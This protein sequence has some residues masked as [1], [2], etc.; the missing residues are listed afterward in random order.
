MLPKRTY[1][2]SVYCIFP[3]TVGKD[4]SVIPYCDYS[5]S[6]TYM[7]TAIDIKESIQYCTVGWSPSQFTC[8]DQVDGVTGHRRQSSRQ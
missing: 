5:S 3:R 8:T 4:G 2:A 1:C 7:D 6:L